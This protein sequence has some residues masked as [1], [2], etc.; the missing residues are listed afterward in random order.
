MFTQCGGGGGKEAA[1][2]GGRL[3]RWMFVFWVG[4]IAVVT[5]ILFA[6]FRS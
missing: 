1:G 3:T 5:G 6:F 2:A 4:Q